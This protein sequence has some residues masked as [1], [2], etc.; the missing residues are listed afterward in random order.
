VPVKTD[1]GLFALAIEPP[2]PLV[3]VHAP[4]PTVGVFP[5]KVVDIPQTAWSEPA[6]ADVGLSLL[7]RTTSST[8]VQEAPFEIVQ[9]RVTDVPRF[10]P[11]T[12]ELFKDGEVI[13]APFAELTIVQVPVP[14]VG[15]LPAKVKEPLLH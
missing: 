7:D 6:V 1:V 15:E 2:V 4:V 9:R 3:I 13:V 11:V 14:D 12:V 8:L 5:A 10:R